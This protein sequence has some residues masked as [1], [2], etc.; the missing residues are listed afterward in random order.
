M[1]L[2]SIR[3]FRDTEISTIVELWR[4]AGLTPPPRDPERDIRT[5]RGSGDVFVAEY[6]ERLV[7]TIMVGREEEH[8]WLYYLA[9]EPAVQHKGLGRAMVR[10]VEKW[11]RARGI[12]KVMLM[13]RNNNRG[14]R[15]FYRRL[16]YVTEP[17]QIMSRTLVPARATAPS[18]AAG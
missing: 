12:A 13:I 10:H 8:G 5:A 17:K 16:G 6:Q 3:S 7:A 14:V 1:S 18:E 11:L 2:V 4:A 9:V 15:E